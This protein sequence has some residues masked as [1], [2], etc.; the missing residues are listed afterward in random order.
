MLSMNVNTPIFNFQF[1]DSGG[2]ISITVSINVM[3]M[4][5]QERK[6]HTKL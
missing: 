1:N 5:N 6:I 3:H 4:Y 2:S